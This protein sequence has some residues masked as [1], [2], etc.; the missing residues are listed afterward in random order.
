[1][2]DRETILKEIN[3]LMDESIDEEPVYRIKKL[4]RLKLELSLDIRDR[5][6]EQNYLFKKLLEQPNGK[7][8]FLDR[9]LK[10]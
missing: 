2:R 7:K 3:L 8:S 5:L 10:R 6:E 1:M 4:N 9:L